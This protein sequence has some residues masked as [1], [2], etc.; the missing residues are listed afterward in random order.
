M[1]RA[2]PPSFA[3]DQ[4]KG[5]R[6]V[7]IVDQLS[8]ADLD[9]L[10]SVH[11][12]AFF[13][14]DRR[15]FA[16]NLGACSRAFA[17]QGAPVAV[18]Y[19]YKT[20]Y[21][22]VLCRAVDAAGGM[23]EVVSATEYALA[24]RLGVPGERIVVNGPGKGATLL[25][26][27]GVE[28]ALLNLDGPGEVADL[29]AVAAR[30]PSAIFRVA[31]R[32]NL[33]ADHGPRPS[34]FGMTADQIMDAAQRIAEQPNCR[35]V[36]LHHHSSTG[37]RSAGAAG[38]RAGQLAR[39]ARQVFGD[40][41]PELLDVGGGFLGPMHPVLAAQFPG[42]LP[43]FDDYAREICAAVAQVFPHDQ[44]RLIVEPGTALVADVVSFA[45]R[46]VEVK[47]LAGRTVAVT[48]GSRTNIR[49]T[50]HTRT[51]PLRV[52]P[53]RRADRAAGMLDV[54]GS[55]C[56][57]D[58]VLVAGH[59]GPLEAGDWLV[60]GGVGAYTV[61]MQPPFIHP[62]PAILAVDHDGTVRLARRRQRLED[63]FAGF[64]LGDGEPIADD[65][66]SLT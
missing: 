3:P 45:C 52:V 57:E 58:D 13:L 62:A 30:R 49:P 54:V 26:T 66:G 41:G 38:E 63:M 34:R 37:T 36:G 42:P 64:D 43:T 47:E 55:T 61:V 4:R 21:T 14:V 20:N 29:L 8:H 59:H 31:L 32:C 24:R 35:L 33:A 22:P 2:F 44:P 46:V 1:M 25:E 60:F 50:G 53:R 10:A 12:A 9:G 39:L 16:A 51:L 15:A 7:G 48:A 6:A 40:A 11:G 28:G 5:H 27:A 56:M 19:S 18:G 23:A 17:D 65:R